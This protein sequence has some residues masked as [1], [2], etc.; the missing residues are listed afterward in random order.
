M[1]VNINREVKEK[2]ITVTETVVT[3]VTLNVSP[4][5]ASL[6]GT[7]LS[8]VAS[9]PTEGANKPELASELHNLWD[10]LDDSVTDGTLPITKVTGT[11]NCLYW[12]VDYSNQT[13]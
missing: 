5:M 10:T 3:G 8:F 12:S 13:K 1:H 2:V 9:T 6:I 7:M 4:E 11:L